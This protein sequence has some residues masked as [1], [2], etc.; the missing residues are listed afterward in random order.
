[1]A[2]FDEIFNRASIYQML[3]FNVKAVLE[4]PTLSELEKN[5]KP[6]YDSWLKIMDGK[7]KNLDERERNSTFDQLYAKY[8]VEYPE[9]SK[10][11]AITYA[12]LYSENGEM[13]RDFKNIVNLDESLVINTFFDV[14]KSLSNDTK[15][16][17]NLTASLCG[18]DIRNYDIPLLIKRHMLK[19]GKESDKELPLILKKILNIKPWENGL[20]DT[21][22]VWKF[23][24][25]GDNDNSLEF[26]SNFLGLKKNMSLLTNDELSKYY[27]NNIYDKPDEVLKFL[28]L[29]SAN[30]TN[31]VI[32]LVK[33]LRTY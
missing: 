29:Q 25:Y 5:N 8:A 18:H 30:Q 11:V 27:W 17:S 12:T 24:G 31:L 7:T 14:L 2:L 26:I 21:S 10:I 6:M 20:V 33:E 19:N 28:G 15:T 23:S 22:N 3:F 9:Y 32:Q 13:K 4:Y 16:M 1:M